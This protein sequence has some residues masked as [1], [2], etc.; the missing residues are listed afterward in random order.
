[1]KLD[2]F[3]PQLVSVVSE[4]LKKGTSFSPRTKRCLWTPHA[5]REWEVHTIKWYCLNSCSPILTTSIKTNVTGPSSSESSYSS[6]AIARD[7]GTRIPQER[8]EPQIRPE[9]TDIRSVVSY[10][11]KMNCLRGRKRSGR[12]ICW[13]PRLFWSTGYFVTSLA[14][15]SKDE[16]PKSYLDNPLPNLISPQ[17][18]AQ[19]FASGSHWVFAS[20]DSF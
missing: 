12:K 8:Q 9:I 2:T 10:L 13:Q 20:E 6:L 11:S 17:L 15:T 19:W 1:M 16:A 18:V 7:T 3:L 4:P 14:N 5:F